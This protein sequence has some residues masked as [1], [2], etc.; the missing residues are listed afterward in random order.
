MFIIEKVTTL[1]EI[2][3]IWDNDMIDDWCFSLSEIKEK[4]G[5]IGGI[6]KGLR[7]IWKSHQMNSLSVF[8]GF[9]KEWSGSVIIRGLLKYT[10]VYNQDT[11]IGTRHSSCLLMK[12]EDGV[13]DETNEYSIK[14]KN[15]VARCS[16]ILGQRFVFINMFTFW[17]MFMF[18]FALW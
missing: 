1:K 6:M 14:V 10:Q 11:L 4:C 12:L 18:T 16:N 9:D 17:F 13:E 2:Q 15:S 7:C 8:V 5:G 3:E